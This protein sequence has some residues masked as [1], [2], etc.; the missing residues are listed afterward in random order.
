MVSRMCCGHEVE[1][2]VSKRCIWRSGRLV[3]MT[4][5]E[6]LLI[7]ALLLPNCLI[8]AESELV[9]FLAHCG[10]VS[11]R[12]AVRIHLCN[13]RRK[14]GWEVI[15]TLPGRGYRIAALALARAA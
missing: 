8:W 15:Q 14:L 7:E 1:I 9:A 12:N 5:R 4:P 2:E 13:I 6:W 11:S 10:V 3:A